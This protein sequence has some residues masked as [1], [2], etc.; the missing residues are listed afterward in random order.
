MKTSCTCRNV[1]GSDKF[2]QCNDSD[3]IRV[4]KNALSGTFSFERYFTHFHF[5]Y[6]SKQDRRT[7]QLGRKR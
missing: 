4:I 7:G 5:R 1:S 2:K 6:L 3:N